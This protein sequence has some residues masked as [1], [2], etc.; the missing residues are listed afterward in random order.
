MD[1][2]TLIITGIF[3]AIGGGGLVKLVELY[4]SSHKDD[5]KNALKFRSF[6]D[7]KVAELITRYEARDKKL[8]EE[9][10]CLARELARLKQKYFELLTKGADEP[11]AD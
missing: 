10:D 9:R 7:E 5:G 11:S 3:S 4:L 2:V 8:E 6:L 1:V